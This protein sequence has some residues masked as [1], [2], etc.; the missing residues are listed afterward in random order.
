M[1]HFNPLYIS[2]V[3]LF[4]TSSLEF[5][6]YFPSPSFIC[7][8]YFNIVCLILDCKPHLRLVLCFLVSDRIES[9]YVWL[10]DLVLKFFNAYLLIFLRSRMC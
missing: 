5:S 1:L 3:S 8:I 2:I 4:W 10:E 6:L 9:D 7:C